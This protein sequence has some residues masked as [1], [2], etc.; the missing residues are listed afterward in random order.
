MKIFSVA[1]AILSLAGCRTDVANRY[2]GSVRYP[3][4]DPSQVALLSDRPKGDFVV[5]ADFQSVGESPED[6]REKAAQIGADAVIVNRVG[7]DY[8]FDE[9][10]AD[11]DKAAGVWRRVV[12]TAIIFK[13]GGK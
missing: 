5:L 10:W 13:K 11:Q 3:A 6:I 9:D 12:G 8:H 4:K 7:G 2:Y 1:V